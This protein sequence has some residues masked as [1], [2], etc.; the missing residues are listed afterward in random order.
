MRAMPTR[1]SLR[2]R[3]VPVDGH[4]HVVA[5]PG[6]EDPLQGLGV[7]RLQ[8][9]LGA[10]GQA[11][12][13]PERRVGAALLVQDHL[14]GGVR[15]LEQPCGVEPARAPAQHRDATQIHSDLP[16]GDSRL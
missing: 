3:G 15:E 14:A 16:A 9:A 13:E 5:D 1:R 2:T 12:A 8:L 7:G 11:D 10:G 6:G 4:R